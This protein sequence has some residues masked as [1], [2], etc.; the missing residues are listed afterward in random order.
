M[1]KIKTQIFALMHLFGLQGLAETSDIEQ[2]I[3]N[4][5]DETAALVIRYRIETG[6]MSP[7][8]ACNLIQIAIKYE[9]PLSVISLLDYPLLHPAS[10][11][12]AGTSEI[13]M[14]GLLAM[15]TSAHRLDTIF[16]PSSS[17]HWMLNFDHLMSA[18][19]HAILLY[20]VLEHNNFDFLLEQ[21]FGQLN[22]LFRDLDS[23]DPYFRMNLLIFAAKLLHY[24]LKV[25][26]DEHITEL[27]EMLSRLGELLTQKHEQ[28]EEQRAALQAELM[29]EHQLILNQTEADEAYSGEVGWILPDLL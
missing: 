12:L 9:Q 18:F 28:Q 24:A 1:K 20:N 5:E 4:E 6:E 15:T 10:I 2:L 21:G 13:R 7:D 23:R 14:I 29:L 19:S 27:K 22:F 26:H 16:N 17:I 8:D 25:A 11:I 3:F